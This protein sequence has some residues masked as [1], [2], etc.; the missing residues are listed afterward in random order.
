M[1][2]VTAGY[3]QFAAVIDAATLDF[4][5]DLRPDLFIVRGSERS[6]DAYQFAAGRFEAQ[7][8]TAGNNTKSVRFKTTGTITIA[9]SLQAGEAP[10]GDPAYIDIGS[11]QWSPGSLVF[12]LSMSDA[13]NWGIGTRSPG[14]NIGYQPGTGEWTISQG[15]NAYNASYVQVSSSAPITNLVYAG[16]STADLGYKPLLVRN[17]VNGLITMANAGFNAARTL[18]KRRS[19]RLR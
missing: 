13:R 1:R 7:F 10:E 8:I 19:G 5:R 12:Q 16:A 18:P 6:S 3:A 11:A 17:T 15:N 4:N 9:A 14:L 2:N